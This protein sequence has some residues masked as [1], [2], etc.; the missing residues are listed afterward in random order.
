VLGVNKPTGWTSWHDDFDLRFGGLPTPTPRW[1]KLKVT[2]GPLISG[3]PQVTLSP[4]GVLT[5]SSSTRPDQT[6]WSSS[7]LTQLELLFASPTGRA[8]HPYKSFFG[9][10]HNHH[11]VIRNPQMHAL[12]SQSL[13]QINTK[14]EGEEGEEPNLQALN[15]AHK[16]H[17]ISR[18]N[19]SSNHVSKRQ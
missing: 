9:A 17:S 18:R 16:G 12:G 19:F 5:M 14:L 6:T 7:R 8:Q 15:L 3:D 2:A 11:A 13:T 10:T 1:D 4:C